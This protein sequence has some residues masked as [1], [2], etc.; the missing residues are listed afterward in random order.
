MD[1]LKFVYP[2]LCSNDD[3]HAGELQQN[4]RRH[5]NDHD[6]ICEYNGAAKA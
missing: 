3:E 6:D 4:V 5:K 1:I 2:D